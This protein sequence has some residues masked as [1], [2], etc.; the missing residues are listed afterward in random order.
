MEIIMKNR[1]LL[2][3]AFLVTGH[4]LQAMEQVNITNSSQPHQLA[5]VYCSACKG[6]AKDCT[7]CARFTTN[8]GVRF[9][10]NWNLVPQ[11]WHQMKNMKKTDG[12]LLKDINAT[13][14]EL[15]VLNTLVKASK[16]DDADM[17]QEYKARIASLQDPQQIIDLMTQILFWFADKHNLSDLAEQFALMVKDADF[18]VQEFAQTEGI[19]NAIEALEDKTHAAGIPKEVISAVVS[20]M[21]I[22]NKDLKIPHGADGKEIKTSISFKDWV[23]HNDVNVRLKNVAGFKTLDLENLRLSDI[24]DLGKTLHN[25]GTLSVNDIRMIWLGN[26]QIKEIPVGAFNGLSQLLNIGLDHNQIEEVPVGIFNGLS[27]LQSIRL[28]S[29][30]IKEISAGVCNGLS[31][32]EVIFLDKNHIKEIPVGAFSG[33]PQLRVII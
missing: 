30:Q 32:L 33:L 14:L 26:N 19:A 16:Q 18:D 27:Q 31:R 9:Y 21:K 5:K 1:I 7:E 12:V 3:C 23:R 29:N 13:A 4:A 2:S 8:D 24:T 11:H 15:S 10:I 28:D 17:R 20:W 6:I 25:S 22:L